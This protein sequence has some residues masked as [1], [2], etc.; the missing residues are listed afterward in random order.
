M[1]V[2][3]AAAALAASQ[4]GSARAG[5]REPREYVKVVD[6]PYQRVGLT[7]TV[8][9]GLG[10]PVRGLTREEF[11]VTEDGRMVDLLDFD[12]EGARRDR[13]L[14]VAVLLDMS[15][16][17]RSQVR[18][19]REAAQALLGGLRPGDEIMLARFNDELTILQP[20]TGDALRVG[21]T[22]KDP[23]RARGGTALFRSIEH[24][25]KDLRERPGR[26]VILV[27]SDGLDNDV[28]RDQHVLQSLYL[29]DL[30]RLCFRTQTTVYG[31]RPGM[32]ASSW[33]PFE[34]FVEE[35][36]GRLLYTGGDLERL[37]ARLGEEFLSQYYLAYDID[38]KVKEGKR[39]RIRVEVAREGVVVKT[40]GGYFTPHSHLETLLLDLE[41]D[42]VAMRA[43]AAYELGFVGDP[44]ATNALLVVLDDKEEK[45]RRLAVAALGRLGAEDTLPR[46][47]E[48]LGDPSSSVREA[49]A[50]SVRSFGPRAIPAL[51]LEIERGSGKRKAAPRV[52]GAADLLGKV[53]DDRALDPLGS[54]LRDGPPAARLAAARALGDLGLSQGIPALRA[55]LADPSPEVRGAS[56]KSIVYIS[57]A[58]ARPVVEDYM[59]RETDP[60]LKAA[61]RAA[62][63]AP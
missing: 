62:L 37:F 39:R 58:A 29:Q 28:A 33:L 32:S 10:R 15:Q 26:K 48:R 34:G 21:K 20:F 22:L 18:K 43:D 41:D 35:T 59:K 49:A 7:V 54:L 47:I 23:G 4:A 14:S 17:M 24:T 55:A 60:G 51:L 46:L 57:E 2:L 42:N 11:R 31:I 45:V 1:C 56:L 63:E 38:P 25:L 27:V 16:S 5:E 44:R 9:D 36:G 6:R 19:V 8:T 53:G 40:M 3:C 12:P 50:S 30:L 61:A 52:L 13:P